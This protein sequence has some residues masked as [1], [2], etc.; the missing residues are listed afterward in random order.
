[1]LAIS[2]LMRLL[3]DNHEQLAMFLVNG[4][5]LVEDNKEF[6]DLLHSLLFG[7][8]SCFILP[9]DKCFVLS[10]LQEVARLQLVNNENPRK[11]LQQGNCT[12]TTLYRLFHDGLPSARLFLVA[13]LKNPIVN[14][15]ATID[16]YLDVDF[17]KM[18]SR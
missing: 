5:R 7:L 3:Y 10:L 16:E 9:E 17:N 1:M 6:L 11:L 8:S 4:E 18:L 15:I 13:C 12:F 14:L 2:D